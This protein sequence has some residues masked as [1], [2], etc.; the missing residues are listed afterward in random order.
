MLKTQTKRKINST[1]STYRMESALSNE[2]RLLEIRNNVNQKDSLFCILQKDAKEFEDKCLFE[3]NGVIQIMTYGN[4]IVYLKA[5]NKYLPA[6]PLAKFKIHNNPE[7]RKRKK[8]KNTLICVL[9]QLTKFQS[10][11]IRLQLLLLNQ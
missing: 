3:G 2:E 1:N 8:R 10:K 9:K 7:N 4:Y 11:L 5:H 6:I